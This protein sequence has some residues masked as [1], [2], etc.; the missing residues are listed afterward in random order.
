MRIFILFMVFIVV[1]TSCSKDNS[2]NLT[3]VFTDSKGTTLS[4]TNCKWLKDSVS[5]FISASLWISGTTNADKVSIRTFDN[6]PSPS[7]GAGVN[8]VDLYLPLD[9]KTNFN[10]TLPIIIHGTPLILHTTIK[11]IKGSDTLVL[12]VD[13]YGNVKY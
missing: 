6:P 12:I 1:V 7:S 13:N 4:I 3:K 9:S 11:A 2:N 8:T 10:D 5:S